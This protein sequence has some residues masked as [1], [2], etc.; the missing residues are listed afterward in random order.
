[1]TFRIA[2][3]GLNA[4]S[5]DLG[6]TAN[7]IAN[8]NSTGFKSSRTEFADVYTASGIGVGNGSA[9][10]GVRVASISQ[11]FSQ[12]TVQYTD[13]NLDLAIS[14]KGF[15]TLETPNGYQYTRAGAFGI[16]RDGY[17]VNS[18]N[19]RLMGYPPVPG[20]TGAATTFN[21]STLSGMQLQTAQ[22]SPQATTSATVGINLTA[23]SA[24]PTVSPFDPTNPNSYNYTTSSPVYD[25]L[26]NLSTAR[27]YFV[28]TANANE[29]QV[30][31]TIDGT[32]VG[33][34]QTLQFSSS[35][36]LISPAT[37]T[38]TLPAYTP[39]TGAAALNLTIN[40]G[41]STQY[42]G[43]F[44]VA[45]LTQDGYASG[46]LSSIDIDDKGVVFARFTNGRALELGQIALSAFPNPQGLSQNGDASWSQ[47]YASGD[48]I[49]GQA[50]S[51]SL[52]SIQAGALEGSNVDLTKE[53]VNMI[54]AQR[55]FQ[56]NAQMISTADQVTQ[57]IINIR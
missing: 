31:A 16:D 51:G 30:A 49:R 10:A 15:F 3:S 53:L 32:Q 38:I 14:G 33:A 42:G 29:W 23:N 26:G 25:S 39:T 5:S 54:T 19:N 27:Y 4:A 22:S 2:L 6:V 46:R 11:Q 21:T 47:T 43:A 57:T 56:A 28:K 9:A 8:S 44:A 12:G 7:N 24:Q 48:V 55:T 41:K 20:A 52:G 13:S 17:I 1:M 35:G 36:A 34:L 40:L 45:E 18:S 50:G 37:G